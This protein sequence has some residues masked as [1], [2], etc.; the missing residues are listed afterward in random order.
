MMGQCDCLLSALA[1]HCD[2]HCAKYVMEVP[3][4]FIVRYGFLVGGLEAVLAKLVW[5][6]LASPSEWPGEWFAALL[7]LSLLF[8]FC[9]L[10]LVC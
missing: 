2:G 10:H 4:L 6:Y 3:A 9:L 1:A 5:A 8:D 7:T